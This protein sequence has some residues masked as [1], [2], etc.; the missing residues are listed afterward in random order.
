MN[1]NHIEWRDDC[2]VFFAK[3]KRN[4]TG[5]GTE[6]PWHVYSNPDNPEV[7]PV[8]GL[9]KYIFSNPEVIK[10]NGKLFPSEHQYNRFIGIFNRVIIDNAETFRSLGV[11]QD[12]WVHTLVERVPSLCFNQ[13]ALFHLPCP[14]FAFVLAGVLDQLRIATSRT[15]RQGIN[16]AVGVQLVRPHY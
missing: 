13:A 1:I 11:Y 12:I 14:P 16:F 8:L 5:E 2:M 10:K 4:Q 3:S 6:K 7:F 9:A 15:K